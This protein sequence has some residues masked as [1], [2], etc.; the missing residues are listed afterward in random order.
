MKTFVVL[1]MHRSDT[2]RVAKGLSH[3]VYVP[4]DLRPPDQSNP[5]GYYESRTFN[6]LN[7]EILQAAGG[8]WDNPPSEDAIRALETDQRINALIHE[9][10]V[11][12]SAIAKKA[13]QEDWGWKDPATTLTA[14]L[15]VPHLVNPHFV[16]CFREPLKAAASF[17]KMNNKTVEVSLELA[18]EY[19]KR[20][21]AFLHW[22]TESK[23]QCQM[24]G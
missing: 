5:K 9:A 13:G 7:R 3:E 2:S 23:A 12:E 16:A 18:K 4:N 20:L 10:V 14:R 24:V 21:L 15:Y 22:F 6:I 11:K 19:N 17:A 8:T 1:G